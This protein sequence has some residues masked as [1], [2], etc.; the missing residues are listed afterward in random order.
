MKRLL[1]FGIIVCLTFSFCACI[2]PQSH[3]LANMTYKETDEYVAILWEGRTYVAY[4]PISK[5]KMGTQIGIVDGDKQ[6]RVYEYVGCSTDEWIISMYISGL[7]DN[8]LLYKE[9]GVQDIPDE[10][11]SEY[12]EWEGME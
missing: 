4:C 6:D 10:I 9:I 5:S 3:D 1:L 12:E 7:M 11:Q 2:A 8:P